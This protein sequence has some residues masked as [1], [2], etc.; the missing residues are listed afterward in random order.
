ME[1]DAEEFLF[2]VF[3]GGEG[4]GFR[5]G[6]LE[7]VMVGV[8]DLV[9]V[10]FPDGC[11]IGQICEQARFV[12]NGQI[13]PAVFP[14]FGGDDFCAEGLTAKMHAVAD[15]ENWDIQLEN[16]LIAFN[17]V[18]VIDACGAARKYDSL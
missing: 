2:F 12:E 7:K 17:R 11:G 9:A 14:V 3:Y 4:A 5:G 6:E 1:L 13:C 10:A 8:L 16:F 18:F 15:A